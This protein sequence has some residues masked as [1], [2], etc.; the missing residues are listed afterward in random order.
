M[1]EIVTV[2]FETNKTT[3]NLLARD[4]YLRVGDRCIVSTKRG[5]ELVLSSM[6]ARLRILIWVSPK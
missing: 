3:A 5:V 2:K 1:L 6:D 4:V